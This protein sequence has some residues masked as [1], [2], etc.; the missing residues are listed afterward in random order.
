[1][2]SEIKKLEIYVEQTIFTII[3]F[4]DSVFLMISQNQLY[5]NADAFR[6]VHVLGYP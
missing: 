6:G 2:P 5:C 4:I 1:M 3:G